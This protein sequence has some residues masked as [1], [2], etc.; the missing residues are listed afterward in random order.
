MRTYDD[1]IYKKVV[2]WSLLTDGI[3]IP[4]E[5]QVVFSESM[6]TYL[7]PG[8]S[9]EIHVYLNGKT[10]RAKMYNINFD[11]T[12]YPTHTNILQIRYSR[13]SEIAKALQAEFT[14]SYQLI[15]EKRAL[16]SPGDRSLIILPPEN[17]EYLAIYTTEYPDTF[18]FEGIQNEEV[19]NF[20]CFVKETNETEYEN[21][22]NAQDEKAAIITKYNVTKI[23]KLNHKIGDNLKLLY[24]YR[25]QICGKLVGEEYDTHVIECHHIEYFTKCLNNN[26]SNI[27]IVCPNHHRIIH[28]CNPKFEVKSK[29]FIYQNGLNEVLQLNKHL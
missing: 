22:M 14:R 24:G 12:K 3:T 28:S 13:G 5:N 10:Y 1:Y 15:L 6:A 7:K 27:L 23:R 4:F 16:R 19:R 20:E 25:C 9:R 2:D 29:S 18:M 21:F 17:Q 11:R 26:A 8:E